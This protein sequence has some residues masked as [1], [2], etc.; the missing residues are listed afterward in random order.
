MAFLA[1]AAPFL[2][3][4]GAAVSA[5][6]SLLGGI[7]AGNAASYQAQVAENNA[8]IAQQNATYALQ[9]GEAKQEQTGLRAAEEGGAIKT[10]LAANN[11]DVNTGSALDVEQGQREKGQLERETVA[12][13]AELQAYGYRSQATGFEAQAGLDEATASEAPIGGALNAAGGLLSSSS[14]IGFKWGGGSSVAS[15]PWS[16]DTSTA[17]A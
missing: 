2:G 13:N 1:A 10:A 15:N 9:A 11:T 4:A 3:I 16:L 17:P 14:A 6:G 8:K 12:N 5:G 7:A